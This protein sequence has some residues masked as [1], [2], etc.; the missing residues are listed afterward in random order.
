MAFKIPAGVRMDLKQ[1]APP[2]QQWADPPRRP[3]S[4]TRSWRTWHTRSVRPM[5]ARR[6]LHIQDPDIFID[7][8]STVRFENFEG[9]DLMH[10][11]AEFGGVLYERN[12]NGHIVYRTPFPPH[13]IVRMWDG[14]SPKIPSNLHP[15]D[16]NSR[17]AY[18][19]C[20]G[21][22]GENIVWLLVPTP[23]LLY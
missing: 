14:F 10:R 9:H 4:G 21:V 20:R 15:V 13:Q 11:M 3:G 6:F 12:K 1:R 19:V 17:K 7:L 5:M 8:Y 16:Y 18:K 22:V 2:L 23:G